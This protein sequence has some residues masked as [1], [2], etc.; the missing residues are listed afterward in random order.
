MLSCFV[1]QQTVKRQCSKLSVESLITPTISGTTASTV[2]TPPLTSSKQPL[3]LQHRDS[4]TSS[5]PDSTTSPPPDRSHQ[6]RVPQQQPPATAAA[7]MS[8]AVSSEVS[9]LYANCYSAPG[10]ISTYIA[11]GL[12]PTV[13]PPP[14]AFAAGH[15]AYSL[16]HLAYQQGLLAPPPPMPPLPHRHHFSAFL[17]TNAEETPSKL[18]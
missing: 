17:D 15:P 2:P 18:P 8:P 7:S 6:S 14:P 16:A 4:P 9:P 1:Y 10:L 12:L 5:H 11:A 13:P 3:P